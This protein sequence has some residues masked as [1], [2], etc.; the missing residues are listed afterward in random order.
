VGIAKS[1]KLFA[2]AVLQKKTMQH[3]NIAYQGAQGK[4]ATKLVAQSPGGVIHDYVPFY[5]APRSPML[6]TIDGGNV[7]NCPYCQADIAHLV[8]TV[9][10]IVESGLPY[11]FYD[12]NATLELRRASAIRR[13]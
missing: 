7:E 6:R 9:D 2:N 10:A 5:F 13:T 4:R 11:V 12:Y 1:K 8:T 3:E